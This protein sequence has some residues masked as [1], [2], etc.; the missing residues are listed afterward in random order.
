MVK[1]VPAGA[2]DALKLKGH[3]LIAN[4]FEISLKY[5]KALLATNGKK[6]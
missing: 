5:R 1:I 3:N 4:Q 6:A 2:I